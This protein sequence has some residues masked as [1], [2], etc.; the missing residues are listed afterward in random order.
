MNKNVKRL[1]SFLAIIVLA[2]TLC[3]P[4]IAD[5]FTSEFAGKLIILHTNDTH[6]NIVDGDGVF[7]YSRIADL[8]TDLTQMGASVLWLDAGD[9]AQGTPLVNLDQGKTAFDLL[10]IAGCD[11]MTLGNHEF[12]WGTDNL[13]SITEEVDF[14]IIC[15]NIY[16]E[17]TGETLFPA[18][19]LLEMDNDM[20]VGIFGLTTPETMTK[21]NP[22]YMKDLTFDAG[23]DLYACAQAQ[24]DELTERGADIII[25]LGHL[26]VD[27]GSAPNRSTDVIDNTTG[28]DIF[29]DGHS[30][31]VM[32]G[33]VMQGETHLLSTGSQ[34][35]YLGYAIY[36]GENVVAGLYDG[37]DSEVDDVVT[38]TNDA[39]NDQLSDVFA[40]TEVLLNGERDPGVRTEE[41]NLGNFSSDA[42]LWAAQQLMGEDY[43]VA[44]ITNGGG[45]RATIDVGEM[46]MLTM[47]TVFPY[48]N[49]VVVLELT[50]AQILEAFEAACYSL[51]DATACF[52][53]VAQIEY[54]VDTSV[55][56]EEGELYPDSTFYA[57][58]NVGGRVT[59]HTIGGEA[60]DPDAVYAIATNDFIA[61][62]GDS[63][64][65]F[66]EPYQ[67]TGYDTS[68]AV[69]DAL[70]N[71][72]Q[73]VLGGVVGEEYAEPE[74]RITIK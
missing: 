71:Y 66:K 37:V 20:T 18:N 25:C 58:A 50:G 19:V 47:K 52:P 9:A 43:V 60:F 30:H 72:V 68:I 13:L 8:K 24:V 65:V 27:E 57:P 69:E 67:N 55:P 51:P 62:G 33:T 22:E 29:I 32:D 31:T 23:E 73:D 45:I 28:I 4:V 61:V 56:Y 36:D 48:G 44:S 54:T 39:V 59:I 63:Y 1:L 15:A 12:D 49:T 11:V 64:Y 14:D 6:G 16:V 74:G 70:V 53:Q 5:Q 34:G 7:G 38:A 35:A 41:T 46:S 2:A 26:G 42:I 3:I 21:T 17:E 10:T 40:T